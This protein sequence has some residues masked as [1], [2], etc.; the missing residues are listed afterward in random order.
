M[1][2]P[3]STPLHL[4]GRTPPVI[5]VA[6]STVV[7]AR[8]DVVWRA[9]TSPQELVR[10]DAQREALLDPLDPLAPYPQVGRCVRWR[11]HLGSVALIARQTIRDLRPAEY[12]ESAISVGSFRFD[13][14]YALVDDPGDEPRTRVSLRLAASNSFPMLGG[15]FDR[16]DVRRFASKLADSSLRAVQAWCEAD[17]PAAASDSAGFAS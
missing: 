14:A 6:M 9:L 2:M 10:W 12:V 4:S 11:Y 15:E 8:R 5:T 13:E 17:R 3:V 1:P 7:A 16:F